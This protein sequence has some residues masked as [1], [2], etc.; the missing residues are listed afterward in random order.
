MIY[1]TSDLHFNHDRDFIYLPR[2]FNS[3]YEMNSAIIKNWNSLVEKDDDVY[4]LGDLMLGDTSLG[5]KCISQLKGNLHII[6]GNHDTDRRIEIYDTLH[7]VVDIKFADRIRYGK[8]IFYLSHYPVYTSNKNEKPIWCLSGHTHSK[9]IFQEKFPQ[10]YNV[11]L[12][13]H[14]NKLVSIE[15]IINNIIAY[16]R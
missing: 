10:N 7:N 2:G 8:W 3:I 5:I 9:E 12:D 6:L 11:A 14:D 16:K 15:E 4:I 13:A 1:L